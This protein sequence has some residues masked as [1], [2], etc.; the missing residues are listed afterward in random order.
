MSHGPATDWGRDTSAKYKSRI[1][2]SMFAL[3]TSVYAIFV[4]INSITP[5]MMGVPLVGLNIAIVYGFGLI[6]FALIL[7]FIYNI[8]CTNMEEKL[9]HKSKMIERWYDHLSTNNQLPAGFEREKVLAFCDALISL[10]AEVNLDLK[11]PNLTAIEAFQSLFDL[12]K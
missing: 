6:V 11:G 9:M 1:G 12:K 4:L 5:K 7:A 3:Y 2:L 10:D 8:M